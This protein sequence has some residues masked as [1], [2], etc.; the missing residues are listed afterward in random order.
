V[1][2]FPLLPV[3]AT[4][5]FLMSIGAPI[6]FGQS[7][8]PAPAPDPPA[9]KP[10][11]RTASKLMAA[12]IVSVSPET[13]MLH[14]RETET[15]KEIAALLDS[16][17]RLTKKNGPAILTG[18]TKGE[19]VMARLMMQVS[20]SPKAD[21][22]VR[23]IWDESSYSAE[24]KVRTEITVGKVVANTASA[25]EV[26]QT[27]GE[28]IHFRV[29]AKTKFLK[30]G[31]DVTAAA[32]P[33]GSNV[34]VKPRGLP[35][36]GV[37]ASMVGES[38]DALNQTHLD[39]LIL[40]QGMISSIDPVSWHITLLRD[41][42]A[43]RIVVVNDTTSIRKRR[44]EIKLGGLATGDYV[45][46]HLIKGITKDGFRTADQISVPTT[47]PEKKAAIPR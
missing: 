25:L 27:K 19:K 41:D 44:K 37:M 4:S 18:F 36:G 26:Q 40:W 47:P 17:S 33:V 12:T 6:A 7:S 10:T 23:D 24:R 32:F 45:K 31:K 16:D 20:L 28:L 21:A 8:P 11:P 1:R 35:T 34:A 46:V 38:A 39:G 14:L 5:L 13:N 9:A 42:N 43:T 15:G 22:T 2:L 30:E 29:S 3:V